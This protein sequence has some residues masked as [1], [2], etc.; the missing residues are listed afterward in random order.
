MWI[1]GDPRTADHA[2]NATRI[3]VEE[4][5]VRSTLPFVHSFAALAW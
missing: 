4:V 1:R 3:Y 2:L 5:E